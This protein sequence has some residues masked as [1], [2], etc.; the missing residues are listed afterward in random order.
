MMRFR[1][2]FTIENL[3][4]IDLGLMIGGHS[5]GLA[6]AAAWDFGGT[7]S[8]SQLTQRADAGSLTS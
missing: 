7:D 4:A 1:A 5:Q 6:A 8:K 2:G 3:G